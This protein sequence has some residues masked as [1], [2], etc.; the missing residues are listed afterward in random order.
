MARNRAS[1]CCRSRVEVYDAQAAHAEPDRTIQK[2]SSVVRPTMDNGVRHA[3]QDRFVRVRVAAHDHAANATH[4]QR[5]S[6]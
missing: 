5:F 6:E 4:A 3:M 2:E 1:C